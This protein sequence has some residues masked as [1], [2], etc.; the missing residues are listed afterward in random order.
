MVQKADID[1]PDEVL[2]WIDQ[3]CHE[4]RSVIA[5]EKGY[6]FNSC[7]SVQN[8][9]PIYWDKKVALEIC[10]ADIAPPSMISV[11]LRPNYWSPGK[12]KRRLA[13]QTHFDLKDIFRLPEGIITENELVFHEP[14]KVGDQLQT[15]QVLRSVSP[16][17]TTRL[18][19]GR[20]WVIDC[21]IENQSGV[22]CA[23][24]RYTGLGYEKNK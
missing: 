5:V 20:F 23:I 24:D 3:R 16:L 6:I 9:N 13:L 7:A 10:G 21:L 12:E 19:V 1:L 4:E 15:V 17:K 18:G 2:G 11:W 14:V 8:A 22:L